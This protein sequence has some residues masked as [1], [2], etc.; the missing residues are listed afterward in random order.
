MTTAAAPMST[1]VAQPQALAA[2]EFFQ[3]PPAPELGLAR[4]AP[5]EPL[6]IW[7]KTTSGERSEHSPPTVVT[8]RGLCVR[9]V[10]ASQSRLQV[11]HCALQ[12]RVGRRFAEARVLRFD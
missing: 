12:L 11:R 5:A 6:G 4:R 1:T 7:T 10:Q 8:K 3:R 2:V 9:V